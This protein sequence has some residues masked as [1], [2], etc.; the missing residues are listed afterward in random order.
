MEPVPFERQWREIPLF[1]KDYSSWLIL[2]DIIGNSMDSDG[3]RWNFICQYLSKN[4]DRLF[5]SECVNAFRAGIRKRI[6]YV[7][8][9]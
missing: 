9:G 5:D 1:C 4:K 2:I 6:L 8:K 3:Q 7:F